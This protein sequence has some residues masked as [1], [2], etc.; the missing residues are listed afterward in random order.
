MTYFRPQTGVA[1][2]NWS[3]TQTNI[4]KLGQSQTS[5]NKTHNTPETTTFYLSEHTNSFYLKAARTRSQSVLRRA[6]PFLCIC[7]SSAPAAFAQ[8]RVLLRTAL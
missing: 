5:L 4:F 3:F 2:D 7:S 6:R 8:T 1:A